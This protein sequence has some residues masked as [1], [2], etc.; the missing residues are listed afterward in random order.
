MIYPSIRA[1][2]VKRFMA[3]F[4]SSTNGQIAY[5]GFAT[6]RQ[7]DRFLAKQILLDRI[8]GAKEEFTNR[9]GEEYETQYWQRPKADGLSKEQFAEAIREAGFTCK[10]TTNY[11]SYEPEYCCPDG[12]GFCAQEWNA[13]LDTIIA[14]LNGATS[15]CLTCCAKYQ[16]TGNQICPTCENHKQERVA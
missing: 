13:T 7:A 3:P 12:Y 15:H 16:G 10:D 6:K 11:Y 9:P 14:Q 5:R 8:F 2:Q 4:V 1:K